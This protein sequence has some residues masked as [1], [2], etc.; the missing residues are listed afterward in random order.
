MKGPILTEAL[1]VQ[2]DDTVAG[3][4]NHSTEGHTLRDLKNSDRR[5]I[6]KIHDKKGF[7]QVLGWSN[8]VFIF[9]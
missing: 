7:K 1:Y 4:P 9:A 3:V 5:G 2:A 6:V 8:G